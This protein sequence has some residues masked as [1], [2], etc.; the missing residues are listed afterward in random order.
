VP[1]RRPRIDIAFTKAKVAVLVN[2]SFWHGSPEHDPVPTSNRGLVLA[3]L[4]DAAVRTA[5]RRAG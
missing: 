3:K 5:V 4:A 1:G 2:S